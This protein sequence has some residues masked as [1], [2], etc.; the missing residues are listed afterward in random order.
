MY[1]HSLL[2]WWIGL[3]SRYLTVCGTENLTSHA[4]LQS[5]HVFTLPTLEGKKQILRVFEAFKPINILLRGNLR[6]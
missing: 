6:I 1:S 2:H 3:T 4:L 5:V